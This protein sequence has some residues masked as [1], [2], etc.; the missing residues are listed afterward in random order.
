[1]REEAEALKREYDSAVHDIDVKSK[2]IKEFEA[3]LRDTYERFEKQRNA[4]KKKRDNVRQLQE[5]NSKL[6]VSNESNQIHIKA[7][8]AECAGLE[9]SIEHCQES[10]PVAV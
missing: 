9:K 8:C 1:M 4:M 7:M 2:Q 5:A 10:G 3:F 6:K